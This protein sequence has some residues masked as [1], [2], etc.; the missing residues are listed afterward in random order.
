MH[1]AQPL[2]RSSRTDVDSVIDPKSIRGLQP[3]VGATDDN[4]LSSAAQLS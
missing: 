2:S 4:D 3:N 1:Y